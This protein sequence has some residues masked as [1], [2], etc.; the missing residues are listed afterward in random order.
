MFRHL[1]NAQKVDVNAKPMPPVIKNIHRNKSQRNNSPTIKCPVYNPGMFSALVQQRL[2]SAKKSE[3]HRPSQNNYS[4]LPPSS[5]H[6]R[7]NN[8]QCNYNNNNQ[9]TPRKSNQDHFSHP[10][11]LSNMMPGTTCCES[12]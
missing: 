8:L 2:S 4:P 12:K 7:S 5:N 1:A 3:H 9:Q 10:V 11:P 6:N